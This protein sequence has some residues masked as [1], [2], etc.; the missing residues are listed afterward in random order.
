MYVAFQPKRFTKLRQL[1][2]ALVSFYLTFSP[3]PRNKFGVVSLSAALSVNAAFLQH[4]LLLTRSMVLCVVRTFLPGIN[5]GAI[6]RPAFI[7][8]KDTITGTVCPA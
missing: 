7:N 2:A 8:H 1:L 6:E 4:C 3:V 5:S